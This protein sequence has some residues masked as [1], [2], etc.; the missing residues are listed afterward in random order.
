MATN[1]QSTNGVTGN[2]AAAADVRPLLAPVDP[3]LRLVEAKLKAVDSSVFA[4]LAEA[5]VDLIGSGGKR[6]RPALAFMAAGYNSNGGA[7]LGRCANVAPSL[8]GG[9]V[10][11]GHAGPRHVIDNARV[12]S[13]ALHAQRAVEQGRRLRWRAT[14]C[15]AAPPVLLRRQQHARHPHLQRHAPDHR[16]RG[17]ASALQAMTTPRTRRAT[18][19][20]STPRRPASLCGH[21]RHAVLTD[22][23]DPRWR[24]CAT[25]NLHGS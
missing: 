5:F 11:H 21:G 6:L 25:Y 13:G 9:D 15:L 3:G 4:P 12:A 24:P 22:L 1:N 2:G 18:T 7:A 19:S 20:A 16:Q 17:T 14:T 8:V 23:A 10:A